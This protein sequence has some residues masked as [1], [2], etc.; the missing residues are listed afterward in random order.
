METVS[1]DLTA[2]ADDVKEPTE[3]FNLR[4]SLSPTAGSLGLELGDPSLTTI[5][6]PGTNESMLIHFLSYLFYPNRDTILQVLQYSLSPQNTL[7]W[8]GILL[9]CF[10]NLHR[11]PVRHI[12]LESPNW[13]EV[14]LIIIHLLLK[15]SSEDFFTE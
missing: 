15:S 9:K 1:V 4:L 8:R 11:L 7:F 3:E 6:I 12:Q 14:T 5:I 13:M 2:L 10:L